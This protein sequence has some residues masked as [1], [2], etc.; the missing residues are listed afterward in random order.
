MGFLSD[1]CTL[2]ILN[3]Q[4]LISSK[5]FSCGNE[6]LDDF[7]MNDC[8]ADS[9]ELMGKTY[10]FTL[11]SDP[12]VITGAFTV[13]NDSIKTTLLPNKK[14]SKINRKIPSIKRYKSYPA[15]LI[16]RLGASIDFKGKGIG[17]E[18]MDAIKFWFVE[19]ENKTGCRYIVVDSY[20]SEKPIAYYQRNGFQ[21]LFDTESD[22][23]KYTGI[24]N[25]LT[26]KQK[27]INWYRKKVN[28][29]ELTNDKLKTRLMYFDLIVLKT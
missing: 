4:T 27:L 12:N 15:V 28:L 2:T 11:N 26:K 16:G 8:V 23:K 14:R 19:S 21:F 6:D 17:D 20:N 24:R 1:Q 13:A 29:P 10:C 25:D 9:N 18:L 3:E 5:P 7:F 22:E